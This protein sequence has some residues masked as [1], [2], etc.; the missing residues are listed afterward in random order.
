[1]IIRK[2]LN[3]IVMV[4][5]VLC[6]SAC[7]PTSSSNEIHSSSPMPQPATLSQPATQPQSVTSTQTAPSESASEPF[8]FYAPENWEGTHPVALARGWYPGTAVGALYQER[9]LFEADGTFY[10][11]GSMSAAGERLRYMDGTWEYNGSAITLTV[12]KKMA[13]EG[14]QV[15]ENPSFGSRVSFIEGGTVVKYELAPQ[16]YET[17]VLSFE[18]LDTDLSWIPYIP[19]SISLDGTEFFPLRSVD[20]E[21]LHQYWEE[22]E[23][24]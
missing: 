8:D 22:Y 19:G 7:A 2:C 10:Y 20:Y 11:A 9:Y 1:M 14:G 13:I 5:L 21:E 6:L 17:V 15:I 23:Y 4:L 12:H 18:I 24:W 16:E 3:I